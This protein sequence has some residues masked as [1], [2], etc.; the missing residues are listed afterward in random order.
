MHVLL[1]TSFEG[2]DRTFLIQR[3]C[4][5]SSILINYETAVVRIV[6]S[7]DYQFRS[8]MVHCNAVRVLHAKNMSHINLLHSL[9]YN[10]SVFT[11][12]H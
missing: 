5:L 8:A 6:N 1:A 3:Y 7:L 11:N 9:H 4:V 10:H 12:P 2:C